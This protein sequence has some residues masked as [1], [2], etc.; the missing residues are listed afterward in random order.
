MQPFIKVE[1]KLSKN[2][3]RF[4]HR[5]TMIQEKV[6]VLFALMAATLCVTQGKGYE[7]CSDNIALSINRDTTPLINQLINMVQWLRVSLSS[8]WTNHC[9]F[10]FVILCQMPKFFTSSINFLDSVFCKVFFF[11]WIR[12]RT[13]IFSRG[14]MSY[15]I[16][17]VIYPSR[18]VQY[19]IWCNI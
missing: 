6:F 7:A 18:I 8:S 17:E 15:Y 4:G 2:Q 10:I 19:T 3:R 13:M 5:K 11:S 12:F 16:Y 14:L 9:V 1:P